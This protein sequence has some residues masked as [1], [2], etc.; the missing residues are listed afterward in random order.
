MAR[1]R[2]YVAERG[3]DGGVTRGPRELSPDDLPAGE[4]TVR[5]AF[6]SVNYKDALATLAGGG[7]ARTSPLVPGI[8]LAGEVVASSAPEVAVGDQVVVHG[9]ELGTARHGGFAEL[10]RVPAGWVVP[11]PDGLSARDA[12]AIGTAGYT[13]GLGLQLLEARGL[14]PGQGPVLVTGASGGL[15]SLAVDML[16]ARGYEVAAST[17][18][19]EQAAWLR[20]LGAAEVLD[21]AETSAPGTRPLERQRWAGAVDAV[22]GATLAYVLRTLRIGAGVAAT[23]NTGGVELATTVLPFI[24]RGVALLGVDSANTP[25]EARRAVWRRLAGDLRPPHLAELTTETDLDGL[26]GVLD[27]IRA[28]QVR[29]RTV[30]RLAG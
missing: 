17:G 1:F 27:A 30:V 5:V 10:A 8:D 25:I 4:V 6:S 21:R 24:L 23:G 11:L 26:E 19:A 7:V 29:G 28:G 18:R 14:A 15:G 20:G 2:A 3:D 9:Y 22:G 16:A 13:A 12:M